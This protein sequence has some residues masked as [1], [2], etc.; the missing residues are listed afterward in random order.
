MAFR[1]CLVG[2]GRCSTGSVNWC[3]FSDQNNVIVNGVNLD[4]WCEFN[5]R[6]IYP[7]LSDE[8]RLTIFVMVI[9]YF[10]WYEFFSSLVYF[11]ANFHPGWCCNVGSVTCIAL[12]QPTTRNNPPAK[13]HYLLS[14][15]QTTAMKCWYWTLTSNNGFEW[16]Q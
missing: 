11:G 2:A 15:M 10:K 6:W 14:T 4:Q 3:K 9:F 1:W 16:N 12:R 13:T 7:N 8:W 5:G